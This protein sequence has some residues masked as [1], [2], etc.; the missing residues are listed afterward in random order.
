MATNLVM[1]SMKRGAMLRCPEC[2]QGALFR[3]YLK[4]EQVCQTCGHDNGQYPA[5][6]APPY[7]TMLIVG[8]LII[9]PILAFPFIVEWS[10]WTLLALLLPI[11]A[12]LT[13]ALLPVVKG[14]VVGLHWAIREK[15]AIEDRK[16]G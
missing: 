15:N 11:L 7:F 4:V 5:D 2:G 1:Q 16:A 3:K 13:L 8:H 12:A 14:A 10:P 6:D 9:A